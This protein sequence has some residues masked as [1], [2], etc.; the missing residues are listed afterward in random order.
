MG[1]GTD[2]PFDNLTQMW[3]ETASH[4]MKACEPTEGSTA[5]PE[6][7]RKGRSD[8]MQIWSEW[9][10]QLMR[11]S[12]FLEAQKQGMDGSLAFRKQIRANLRRMQRE[13]QLAG[14][15]DIDAL[16]AA[17]RRSQRRIVDELEENSGRLQALEAKLDRLSERIERFMGREGGAAEPAAGGSNGGEEME[18]RVEARDLYFASGS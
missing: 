8:L 9:C 15:E 14:R 3:L 2:N 5:S 1:S 7:F 10:E 6:V 12:A 4:V 18:K 11:S 16:V 13:L 17:V